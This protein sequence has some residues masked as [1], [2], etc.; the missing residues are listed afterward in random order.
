M[1]FDG[2]LRFD[3]PPA[4]LR[5]VA[6]LEGCSYV[7]LLG[8]AMPLKYLADVPVAVTIVGAVHG[9]LFVALA[10]LTLGAMQSRG[11]TFG[12]GVR[13]AVAS[14]IPFATFALDRDLRAD[15]ETFRAARA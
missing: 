13:M 14:L 11:K 5:A 1:A 3:T 6:F 10:L 4:R 8:V 12:F 2:V 15:D 9:A 7:L